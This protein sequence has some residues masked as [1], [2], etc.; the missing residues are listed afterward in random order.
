MHVVSG[1]F[2]E[3]TVGDGL[4]NRYFVIQA[5]TADEAAVKAA[6]FGEVQNVMSKGTISVLLKGEN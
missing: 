3:V 5:V 2:F 1:R 4:H 6:E